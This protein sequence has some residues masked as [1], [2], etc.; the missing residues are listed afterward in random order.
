MRTL[1]KLRLARRGEGRRR[2]VRTL[3]KLGL[4]LFSV[5]LAAALWLAVAGE[6]IA[7]RG[8]RIPLAFENL[9]EAMEILGDAPQSVEV[10]LRGS[11]GTLRRLDG[12]DLVAIIDLESERAGER[13]FD[14][15]SGRVRAP[16][17][18][19]VT[20]VIPSTISLTLDASGSRVA[21]IVPEIRGAP[22][23]GFVVGDVEVE[24]PTVEVV[25]P[26]SRLHDLTEAM[27]EPIDVTGMSV[28]LR[29]MVTVGLDDPSL[30]LADP[31][32]ARVTIAIVRAPGRVGRPAVDDTRT[33]WSAPG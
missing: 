16:L 21:R 20:Q 8:V 2:V 15:T 29:Q 6:P 4:K 23:A 33:G 18:I 24:P 12:R 28:P 17:G 19:E 14:M 1:R 9:P 32:E 7:E 25:G 31:G 10:R 11:S 13:I 22:A 5:A 3:R 26:E 27:T 30:R